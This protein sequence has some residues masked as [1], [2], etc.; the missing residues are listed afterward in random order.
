MRVD[1]LSRNSPMA[2]CR[3]IV[4]LAGLVV[5]C[6]LPGVVRAEDESDVRINTEAKLLFKAVLTDEPPSQSCQLDSTWDNYPIPE[7]VA[8]K[9]LGLRLHA[10]LSSPHSETIPYEILN[11]LT[12]SCSA[13]RTR[14]GNSMA[15]D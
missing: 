13:A 7:S 1:V 8:R 6:G 11:R 2:D 15:S 4:W 3:R 5:C 12:A 10:E 9:Y 14:L